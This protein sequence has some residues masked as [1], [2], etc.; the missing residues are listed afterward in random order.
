N[1]LDIMVYIDQT[2]EI[3]DIHFNN[4]SKS[5]FLSDISF[6]AFLTTSINPTPTFRV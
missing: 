2:T 4:F 6:T 5:E 1:Q 3:T